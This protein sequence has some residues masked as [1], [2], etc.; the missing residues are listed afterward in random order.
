MRILSGRDQDSVWNA[1]TDI[2]RHN[3]PSRTGTGRTGGGPQ[4]GATGAAGGRTRR[5]RFQGT[6]TSG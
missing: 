6:G 2:V 4:D 1:M 3:A 5:D